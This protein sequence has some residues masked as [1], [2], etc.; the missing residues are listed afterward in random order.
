MN[1]AGLAS[2]LIMVQQGTKTPARFPE[3]SL[4]AGKKLRIRVHSSQKI[5]LSQYF[6]KLIGNIDRGI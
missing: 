1:R 4:T 5:F 6:N 3:F 2:R